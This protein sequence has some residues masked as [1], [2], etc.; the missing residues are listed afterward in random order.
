[1][2]PLLNF[3]DKS[4]PFT[5]SVL[6]GVF[7]FGSLHQDV[8]ALKERQATQITDHDTIVRMEQGQKDIQNDLVGIK[9]TLER[10]EQK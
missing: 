1:M 5:A 9:H 6:A 2:H 7:A 10:I 8:A 4:W 3:L